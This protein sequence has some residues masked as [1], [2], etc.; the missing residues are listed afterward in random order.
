MKNLTLKTTLGL[1]IVITLVGCDLSQLTKSDL[2]KADEN[3]TKPATEATIIGVWRANI[4][5][6]TTNPP[7]DFK[8]TMDIN[9]GHSMLT[10][11]RVATGKPSPNDYIELR[12]EFWSWQVIDGKMMSAKTTCEYKDPAT[13]EPTAETECRAPLSL[14]APINV[15]GPSWTVMQEDQPVIFTKR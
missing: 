7:T 2:T 10:S 9:A 6:T 14:E 5:N 15:K 11:L 13:G 1:M 12:H 3:A 8:V 4:P